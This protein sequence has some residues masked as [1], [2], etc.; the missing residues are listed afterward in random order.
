MITASEELSKAKLG[1]LAGRAGTI[2]DEFISSQRKTKGYMVQ[3]AEA[4]QDE[5]I[6]FIPIQSIMFI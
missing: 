1:E 6:W 2:L 5:Y 4:Y 3:L